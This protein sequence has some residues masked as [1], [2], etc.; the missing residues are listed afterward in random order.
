MISIGIKIPLKFK[1]MFLQVRGSVPLYWSQ[2]GIKYRPPPKLDNTPEEDQVAFGN[3]FQNEFDLYGSPITCVS[4]VEKSGRE[5]IIGD[6]YLDNALLFNRPDLNFVYFDFHEFCRGMK[7]ENVNLLLQVSFFCIIPLKLE[8]KVDYFGATAYNL[9]FS[10]E[11]DFLAIF[12][13]DFLVDLA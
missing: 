8:D 1:T 4:L 12:R 5:K 10:S 3:H 9:I 6:A 13:Q 2:P 7:F 11:T